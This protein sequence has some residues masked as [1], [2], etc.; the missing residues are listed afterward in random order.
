MGPGKYKEK[1][2]IGMIWNCNNN[3]SNASRK[4]YFYPDFCYENV[5]VVSVMEVLV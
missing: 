1:W 4:I 3:Q 5:F 2:L